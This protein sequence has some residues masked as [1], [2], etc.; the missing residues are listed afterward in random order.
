[1][2]FTRE[3]TVLIGGISEIVRQTIP[4]LIVFGL[5]HWTGEQTAAFMLVVGSILGFATIALTRSQVVSTD[6]ADALIKTALKFPVGTNP[7]TVKAEQ[8]QK[9]AGK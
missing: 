9:D 5:I 4:A 6:A 1:M 7:E 3:P 8:A 2:A